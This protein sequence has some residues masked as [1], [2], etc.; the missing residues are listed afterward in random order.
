MSLLTTLT[1][2]MKTA[3]KAGDKRRLNAIRMLV[4]A[5]RYAQI[6]Q[7][8]MSDEEMQKILAREAKK[9]RESVEAYKAAGRKEQAMEEEYELGLIVEYLPE[10]MSETK[11]REK[12]KEIVGSQE[13]ANYGMLMGRVMGELK[14][15]AEGGLISRIVKEEY[16]RGE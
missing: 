15:K 11:V 9:R 14:G 7:G 4:S 3:M 8:E 12:V 6:D 5:I 2:E 10:M 13:W 1:N 16:S